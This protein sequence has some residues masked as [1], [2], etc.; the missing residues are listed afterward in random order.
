MANR[1]GPVCVGKAFDE[2]EIS[3]VRWV[4]GGG[5]FHV[6]YS[7]GRAELGRAGVESVE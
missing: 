6:N 2:E 3:A 4:G 5:V 7:S 1:S